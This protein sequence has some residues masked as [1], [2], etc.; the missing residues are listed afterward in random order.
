MRQREYSEFEGSLAYVAKTCVKKRKEKKTQYLIGYKWINK[1]QFLHSWAKLDLMSR[2][3]E[4][5]FKIA[6]LTLV[7]FCCAHTLQMCA[8]LAVFIIYLLFRQESH[9]LQS[10]D[11]W[12]LI[13]LPPP[14]HRL[15]WHRRA[16]PCQAT[17]LGLSHGL[18]EGDKATYLLNQALKTLSPCF[19]GWHWAPEW[20][21]KNH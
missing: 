8:V 14:P 3:S 12:T 18:E 11:D 17:L 2:F 13:L 5:L 9:I 21:Q 20:I 7:E 19:M 1:M 16:L 10:R 15:T 6:S 4:F